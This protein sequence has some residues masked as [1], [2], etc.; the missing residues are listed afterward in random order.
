MTAGF[1][2][3]LQY[4]LSQSLAQYKI[5]HKIDNEMLFMS[6]EVNDSMVE[7]YLANIFFFFFFF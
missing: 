3:K 4:L 5:L 7:M 6:Y 1:L 2:K